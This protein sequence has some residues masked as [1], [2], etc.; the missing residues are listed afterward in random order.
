MNRPVRSNADHLDASV[1]LARL[2]SRMFAQV[3][4][5]RIAQYQLRHKIGGGGMGLVFAAW[6][7]SLDRQVAIKVL[8]DAW[9]DGAGEQLR[10][11]AVALARLRHPAVVSVFEVGEHDGQVYLAMEYVEGETLRRW[12]RTWR[13]ASPRDEDGLIDVFEQAARGLAAAHAADVVHRDVK[14]ENI[15]IDTDGRARLMD[16]GL[17]RRTTSAEAT[18]GDVEAAPGASDTRSTLGLFGTPAYM[19]PEQLRGEGAGPAVD[20]FGLAACMYEALSGRRVRPDLDDDAV[21]LDFEGLLRFEPMLRRAL[22]ED[23]AA[24]FESMGAF[25]DALGRLRRSSLRRRSIWI[26]GIVAAGGVAVGVLVGGGTSK[27]CTGSES[28]LAS[29]WSVERAGAIEAAVVDPDRPWTTS[30]WARVRSRLDDYGERWTSLHRSTCEAARE[31]EEISTAQMDLRMACLADRRRHLAAFVALLDGEGAA[32]LPTADRGIDELPDLDACT[33]PAY[34]VRQGYPD[35]DEEAAEAVGARLAE[36]A[37]LLTRGAPERARDV[38]RDALE[39]AQASND[40]A[41]EARALL[42]VGRSHAILAEPRDAQAHLFDAYERA[43]TLALADVAAE[44]ATELARVTGL[45]LSRFE[46]GLWW[47]RIADLEGASLESDRVDLQR[48]LV[49]VELLHEAGRGPLARARAERLRDALPALDAEARA[50]A[51][52]RLGWLMLQNGDH[53]GGTRQLEVAAQRLVEARGADH[54]GNAVSQ[55]Q[56]AFA[57]RVRGD[58]PLA[59][60]HTRRALELAE[61][62]VSERHVSLAPYL[63]VLALA[64]FNEGEIDEALAAIDRGLALDE[65]HPLGVVWQ[66]KLHARRGDVLIVH[67]VRG[68]LD[69]QT[70]AYELAREALGEQHRDT[71]S[72][73]VAR[74]M[75]LGDLGRGEKAEDVM[76][77][78]LLLG[79]AT[80]GRAHPNLGTIHGFLATEYQRQGDIDRALEHHRQCLTIWEGAYGSES[81]ALVAPLTNICG[82][83]ALSERAS[84]ALPYCDRARQIHEARDAEGTLSSPDI[85]NNRGIALHQLG[86][87]DDARAEYLLARKAWRRALGPDTY[88]ESIVIANLAELAE[89]QGKRERAAALYGE[90]LEIRRAKLG[91]DH[92]ALAV[93]R[94]GLARTSP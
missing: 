68:A 80:M 93:P 8:R 67:D 61:S 79:T 51:E 60:T 85:H 31:R 17:A 46:Q 59:A 94:D 48:E 78:A 10:R 44:A 58:M 32:S 22:D 20:Q 5:P 41:A 35:A 73:L 4:V 69:A 55:R 54:P 9:S 19:A 56:L 72:Y 38:A 50:R 29:V 6:D 64:H 28:H 65:P 37:A 74:G 87:L 26:G 24:R 81:Y 57:A 39:L 34:V 70:R 25:A 86:R 52:T 45:G 49:A 16:F 7:P 13:E 21:K 63:S 23:P 75:A 88:E 92:P 15:M 77:T 82:A 33:D 76:R 42:A 89:L 11:E 2:R 66:A 14:P 47:L 84:E 62:G 30:S 40:A 27:R 36:A 91:E 1:R 71:L 18:R 90:A 12:A 43:R 83:L 3:E 53:D